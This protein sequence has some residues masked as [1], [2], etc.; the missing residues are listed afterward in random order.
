MWRRLWSRRPESP[1]PPPPATEPTDEELIEKVAS[2][3]VSR[4]LAAPATFMLESWK[5]LS[6]VASQG[7][8]VL[9]PFV[10]AALDIP[11]YDAF[12]RMIEKRENVEKLLARVEELEDERLS[13]TRAKKGDSPPGEEEKP[14]GPSQD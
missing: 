2:E 8:I 11:S 7:L 5:P 12:C 3:I 10:D 1:E 6:F 14:Y 4:R 9:G 13:R